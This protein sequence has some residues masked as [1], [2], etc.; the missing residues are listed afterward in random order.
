MD[1]LE[2]E[3]QKLEQTGSKKK[4][5]KKLPSSESEDDEKK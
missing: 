4:P 1:K 5:I 2:K 3:L